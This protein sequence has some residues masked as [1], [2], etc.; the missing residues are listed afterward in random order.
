MGILILC[1]AGC[2]RSTMKETPQSRLKEARQ[3][4]L[5]GWN[6]WNN[7]NLLCQVKMPE[8]LS[9]SLVFRKKGGGPYWLTDNYIAG[10]KNP[11]QE[12]VTPHAHAY[13]GSYTNLDIEWAG[14][15]ANV[16]SAWDKDGL[17]MLYTPL[18]L[19]E[20]PPVM[21]FQAAYLW[22]KPGILRKTDDEIVAESGAGS[23][24]IGATLPETRYALPLH[25]PYL[26]FE[27]DKESGFYAGKKRSLEEIKA[28]LTRKAEE[29]AKKKEKYGDLADA[30][31]AM[32]SVMAWNVFY[33]AR[34]DRPLCSVSRVW[35]EA[36]GGYIIFDWDTYFASLMAAVDNKD[37]AYSNAVAI[38]NSITSGG[39]I[40]N[41]DASFN[42]K[43]NDRSQPPVGSLICRMIYDKFGEKWFIEDVYDNLLTWNRWWPKARDNQ[44]YLS[45]GSDSVPNGMDGHTKQGAKWESGLDNS[46]LFDEATF[47][48]KTNML[49]L[50]SAGLMG[51]YVADCKN[52]AYLA[53]QLGRAD[54][55]KELEAR[56]E[57]YGEK[58]Q[59]LWDEKTGIYRDRYLPSGEFSKH[60]APTN[61]YPLLSGVPTPEQAERMIKEHYFNPDEF[62]GEWVMPSISR[63][64]P[65]FKDNSYWRGRIWAPMNFLVYMGMRN[66]DLPDAQ[67]D[68]SEKSLKL[69]LKEWNEHRRVHENYNSVTGVG[70]DVT[71]SNS[72]YSW[73]GLLTMINLIEDGYWYP[74]NK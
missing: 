19:P 17:V 36:W 40:P 29:Q 8:G 18:E 47:N 24:T 54:D 11:F 72:F 9:V 34:N 69:I 62:Y 73:G 67:K 57:K 43:S 16:Q 5:T 53:G 28:L 38:T 6:T 50:A 20:K 66:Y 49:D 42:T 26:S 46:P 13:D 35:N 70:G 2:T 59:D 22:D 7:P 12:N 45:W 4:L 55:V 44:G 10:P 3:E 41:V 23:T 52:L 74:S 32:Q 63:N 65:G 48:P 51:L 15:K 33:D 37:L 60:L 64:D 58:L 61:F 27:S 1:L 30:Y 68:L 31:D 71:N 39:F 56:A 21:L 25:S 14:M